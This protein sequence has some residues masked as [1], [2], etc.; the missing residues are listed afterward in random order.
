M[1]NNHPISHQPPTPKIEV[2]IADAWIKVSVEKYLLLSQA[3]ERLGKPLQVLRHDELL[4]MVQ[5]IEKET[6]DQ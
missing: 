3:A 4:N 1:A 6:D 5:Q 2:E